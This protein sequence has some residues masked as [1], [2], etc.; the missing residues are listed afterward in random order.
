MTICFSFISGFMVGFEWAEGED[1]EPGCVVLDLFIV[2]IL[3]IR[4]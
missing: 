4:E 2:R 1:G 3:L